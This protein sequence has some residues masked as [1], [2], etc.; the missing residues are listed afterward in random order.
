MCL[1]LC[2]SWGGGV[3]H[4]HC[5][6]KQAKGKQPFRWLDWCT[7]GCFEA[8]ICTTS[9]CK[10]VLRWMDWGHIWGQ[11]I[12]KSNEAPE[13]DSYGVSSMGQQAYKHASVVTV[14]GDNEEIK[15]LRCWFM[16]LLGHGSAPLGHVFLMQ[17]V[18]IK[19]VSFRTDEE[20]RSPM[21]R[22]R[23]RCRSVKRRTW[24][25]KIF[26]YYSFSSALIWNLWISLSLHS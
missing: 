12:C 11:L 26:R 15:V 10:L 22:K 25:H 7:A 20:S 21:M 2:R 5:R 9:G 14:G 17:P 16:G 13:I 4:W 3:V 23:R 19:R 8:W 24:S 1:F 18:N 6:Q